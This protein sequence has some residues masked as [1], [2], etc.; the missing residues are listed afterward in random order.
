MSDTTAASETTTGPEPTADSNSAVDQVSLDEVARQVVTDF[1]VPGA[2]IQVRIDGQ[3]PTTSVAGLADIDTQQVLTETDQLRIYSVTKGVTAL[4]VLQLAED[5]ILSLDDAVTDWL[6]ESVVGDVPNSSQMT[7]R[8]LLSH[9]SGTADYL[10]SIRPGDEMPPF[11]G[12]LFAQA[13]TG[14]YHWYSPQELIDFSTQ[15][16]SPF[17]PGEGTAYSNTG[18][19]MLG[20]LIES[21]TGNNLEDEMNTRIFKPLGLT[22]TYLE[23]PTSANDYVAGYQQVG[24][25]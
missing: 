9:S 5:G 25:G 22:S 18:Y 2:V 16:D 3:Q 17:P 19:V 20:L 8:H 12:E 10:D 13:Q 1:E 15:F 23:T 14:E 11:V 4:I 7:I 21:A 24:P 6:G